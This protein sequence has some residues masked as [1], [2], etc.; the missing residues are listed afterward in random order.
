MREVVESREFYRLQEEQLDSFGEAL[1]M[2]VARTHD[3]H[4]IGD[5]KRAEFLC[6]KR[7]IQPQLASAT[8]QVCSIGWCEREQKWYG[9]SHRAM[10]GFGIGSRI[11]KGDCGYDERGAWKAETLADAKQMAVDFAEAVA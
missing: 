10:Y 5:Q 1:T 9:W 11:K 4:Y 6:D 8:N 2:T 7:G 3:G